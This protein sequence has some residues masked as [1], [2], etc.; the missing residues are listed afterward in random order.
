MN[1]LARQ[2]RESRARR[3]YQQFML[4]LLNLMVRAYAAELHQEHGLEAEEISEL[5][6]NVISTVHAAIARYEGEYTETALDMWCK[7][8]GFDARVGLDEKGAVVF[9]GGVIERK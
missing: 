9:K 6:E 1:A 2:K 3:D 4:D 5:T 8:F 7:S